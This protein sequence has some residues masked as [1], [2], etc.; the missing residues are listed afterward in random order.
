[1]AGG[2]LDR[3]A[4]GSMGSLASRCGPFKQ[5]LY[6]Y[7]WSSSF[8]PAA[9]NRRRSTS[10]GQTAF[11]L[12]SQRSNSFHAS[13]KQRAH[14]GLLRC[15]TARRW[16]LRLLRAAL[17]CVV[18]AAAHRNRNR[19]VVRERRQQLAARGLHPHWALLMHG[20][21]GQ[22]RPRRRRDGDGDGAK[23]Y[24]RVQVCKGKRT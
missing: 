11:K 24:A 2:W 18:P 10:S 15:I 13:S 9:F 4:I 17:A 21:R 7:L 8:Q 5:R 23:A 22:E 19:G 16:P 14:I 3:A 1:V 20:R 12:S 6:A